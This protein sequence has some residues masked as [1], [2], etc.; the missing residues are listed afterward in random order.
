MLPPLQE[1]V[2]RADNTRVNLQKTTNATRKEKWYV[3]LWNKINSWMMDN[4]EENEDRGNNHHRGGYQIQGQGAIKRAPFGH[5]WPGSINIR[6][7]SILAKNAVAPALIKGPWKYKP[8]TLTKDDAQSKVIEKS[9]ELARGT[10][11]N[12]TIKYDT[13]FEEVRENDG[14][15][16]RFYYRT[17][18]RKNGDSIGGY[19]Y[20]FPK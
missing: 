17:T 18:I 8:S 10:D 16:H 3:M 13:I 7:E 2:I 14:R 19:Y 4:T 12:K 6:E 15:V 1:A 5:G 20:T 9:V 11:V